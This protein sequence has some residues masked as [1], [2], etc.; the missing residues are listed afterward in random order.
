[1]SLSKMNPKPGRVK[2][3]TWSFPCWTGIFVDGDGSQDHGNQHGG[4]LPV[5]LLAQVVLGPDVGGQV[6][7]DQAGTE[8]QKPPISLPIVGIVRSFLQKIFW[9]LLKQRRPRLGEARF[10]FLTPALGNVWTISKHRSKELCHLSL[11]LKTL[12]AFSKPNPKHGKLLTVDFDHI[13]SVSSGPPSSH[14]EQSCAGRVG[15]HLPL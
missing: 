2:I 5:H 4:T 11:G 6:Q 10:K 3:L 15:Q 9:F 13:K 12:P 1:M 14:Y 8:Q 7:Q